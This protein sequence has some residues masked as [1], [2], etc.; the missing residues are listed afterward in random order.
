MYVWF[1]MNSIISYIAFIMDTYPP[2]PSRL[3]YPMSDPWPFQVMHANPQGMSIYIFINIHIILYRYILS[4]Y[5][6]MTYR[7]WG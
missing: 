7:F 3:Q 5:V 6:S 2:T 1:Y 4:I